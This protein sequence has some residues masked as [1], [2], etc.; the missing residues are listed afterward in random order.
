MAEIQYFGAFLIDWFSWVKIVWTKKEPNL[1]NKPSQ[2]NA[3]KYILYL[4]ERQIFFQKYI[5]GEYLLDF[6]ISWKTVLYI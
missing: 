2:T 5:F 4:C 3:V 6:E 1:T